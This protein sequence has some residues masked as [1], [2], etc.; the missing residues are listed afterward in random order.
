MED[1]MP[2]RSKGF[3]GKQHAD[4]TRKKIQVTQIV[5]RL[6]KVALGS[7]EMTTQQLKAAE[8]LLRKALPD[9][10][11]VHS[12]DNESV[13]FEDWLSALPEEAPT[14]ED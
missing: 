2:P 8:I 7:E 4:K 6:N 3:L 12:T 9:L 5:N 14:T 13:S 10:S 11:A 1:A